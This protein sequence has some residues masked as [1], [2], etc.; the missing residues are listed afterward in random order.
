MQGIKTFIKLSAVFHTKSLIPKLLM[1]MNEG[2]VGM[3]V[4]ITY[5]GEGKAV[6]I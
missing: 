1:R 5:Y 6:R 4:A 2:K 3:S